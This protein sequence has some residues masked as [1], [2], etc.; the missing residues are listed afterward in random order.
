MNRKSFLFIFLITIAVLIVQQVYTNKRTAKQ[1]S[2]LK[3]DAPELSESTAQRTANLGDLPIMPLYTDSS[4]TTLA[5]LSIASNGNYLSYAWNSDLPETLYL[6]RGGSMTEVH[7]RTSKASR[8]DPIAY[9]QEYEQPMISYHLPS[10]GETDTQVVWFTDEGRSAHVTLGVHENDTFVFPGAKPDEK[11]I[12]LMKEGSKYI[13]IGFLKDSNKELLAFSDMG[14]FNSFVEYRKGEERTSGSTEYFVLENEYQQVVFSTVGGAISE[15]N[16]PFRSKTNSASVVK[17]IGIDTV[18]KEKYKDNAF[19]PLKKATFYED[20]KRVQKSPTLGGYT[21]LFRRGIESGSRTTHAVPPRFYALNTVSDEEELARMVYKVKEFSA[22]HI[23]FEGSD[24]YRRIVKTFRLPK[25]STSAPYI[26]ECD[27]RVDGDARG[28][29]ITSGIP[30]VELIS[31]SYAPTLR[32]NVKTG[33]KNSIEKIKLPKH[34]TAISS[35]QPTWLSNANGFFGVIVDPTSDT[36]GGLEA[37]HIDGKKDPSRLSVIDSQHGLYPP[38]KF[39]GYEILV[40]LKKSSGVSTFRIFAGPY[41]TNILKTVDETYKTNYIGAKSITGWYSFIAEPFAKF[42]YLIMNLFYSATGSWGFSIILLTVVLRIMMFPLN[43]WSIKST[44]RMQKISP[45]IAKLQEKHKKD[46]KRVQMET[47]QLYKQHKANPFTGCLPMIIQLPFLFGMFELLKTT[48]QLRGAI[49]IPGWIN[50][51]AAPDNLFSWSTPIPFFGTS[52]HLLP[53]ILGGLMVAQSKFLSP[54]GG[55][56]TADQQKQAKTMAYIMPIAMTF[57]FYNFP[58][59]LNLYWISSSVLDVLQRY[60]TQKKL[61]A[62]P[63]EVAKKVK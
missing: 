37:R 31:G 11:A 34:T 2:A 52:F 13:P 56:G 45:L 27:V 46:P 61:S 19:Y 4:G 25:D 14:E 17:P 48:F 18:L 39:A 15:I 6:K 1:E 47:L 20:G 35:V 55:S 23:V 5:T 16:L 57:I 8:G 9:S 53:F 49:F 58:S 62:K 63:F 3:V 22:K 43:N 30:E 32:Y 29:Y 60:V 51:L 50:N 42:L 12:V 24:S 38:E 7:L 26:I 40:P 36:G 54:T 41:E 44:V 33:T 59:G 21:P 10:I 28:L